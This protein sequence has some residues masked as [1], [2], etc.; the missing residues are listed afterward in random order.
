MK[1]SIVLLGLCTLLASE[2][3][4]QKNAPDALNWENPKK[5]LKQFNLADSTFKGWPEQIDLDSLAEQG[6]GYFE[7]LKDAKAKAKG[8]APGVLLDQGVS[9]SDGYIQGGQKYYI[10]NFK[11]MIEPME[12]SPGIYHCK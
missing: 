7:Q 10:R 9:E 1:S 5:L 6:K 2:V 11:P 12:V 4:A 8:F 3:H